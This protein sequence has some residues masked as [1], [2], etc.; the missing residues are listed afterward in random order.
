MRAV[1]RIVNFFKAK[2][3]A[4][5]LFHA[6]VLLFNWPLLSLAAENDETSIFCYLLISWSIIVALLIV[7]GQAIRHGEEAGRED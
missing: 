2:S 3:F 1:N 5:L 4:V 6:G 7:V